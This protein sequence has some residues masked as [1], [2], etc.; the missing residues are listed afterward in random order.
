MSCVCLCV[1]M[2]IWLKGQTCPSCTAYVRAR[3]KSGKQEHFERGRKWTREWWNKIQKKRKRKGNLYCFVV[4]YAI[5]E[6]PVSR[7]ACLACS[8]CSFYPAPPPFSFF[9]PPLFASLPPFP[10]TETNK[11]REAQQG[12]VCMCVCVWG[13]WEDVFLLRTDQ[14]AGVWCIS[15]APPPH[16][17]SWAGLQGGSTPL[18]LRSTQLL[19]CCILHWSL[20]PFP[21]L[22]ACHEDPGGHQRPGAFRRLRGRSSTGPVRS[23]GGQQLGRSVSLFF[24]LSLS[25]SFFFLFFFFLLCMFCSCSTWVA[26]AKLVFEW[27]GYIALGQVFISWEYNTVTSFLNER[28]CFAWSFNSF[29]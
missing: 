21:L 22:D 26:A 7:I 8:V 14:Q 20:T 3:V 5:A 9:P 27:S 24:C 15:P 17:A 6:V 28:L 1:Y 10:A 19:L 25:F 13:R 2:C 16:P 12:G 18:N 23:N 29:V 11:C 4:M